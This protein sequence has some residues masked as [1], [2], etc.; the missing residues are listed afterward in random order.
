MESESKA[1]A[2]RRVYERLADEF[3]AELQR[4]K[5][6]IRRF[7]PDFEF[8]GEWEVVVKLRL[9]GI[10]EERVDEALY[11]FAARE[12]IRAIGAEVLR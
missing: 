1:V 12:V 10:A 5:A 8:S 4:S 9:E 2:V 7:D 3:N 6:A 11:S